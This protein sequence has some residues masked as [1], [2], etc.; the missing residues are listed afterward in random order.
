MTSLRPRVIPCLQ[1]AGGELVKTR[2]FKDPLYLGDPVNAVKLFNDLDCDELVVVDIRATLDQR[3]PD[4]A[5]IE[6]LASE[7]FMPLAYGG[8]ISSVEQVRRILTIGFE[9]VVI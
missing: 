4:Y 8:G 9:K 2:R 6:E 5:L 7:A 1:V 3:D